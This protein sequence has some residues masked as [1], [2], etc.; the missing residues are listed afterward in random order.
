MTYMNTT[1]QE[2]YAPGKQQPLYL[3]EVQ[4]LKREDRLEE[5]IDYLLELVDAAEEDSLFTGL[6][7]AA[8]YYEELA[9]IFRKRKEYSK[10]LSILVRYMKQRHRYGD[11]RQEKLQKRLEKVK[12]LYTNNK[13]II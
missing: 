7:V 2:G 5:A 12:K 11:P 6:G 9:I 10:E 3:R 13:S 8:V 4:Q 1:H